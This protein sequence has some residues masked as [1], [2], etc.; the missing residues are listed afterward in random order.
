MKFKSCRR[1]PKY[2]FSGTLTPSPYTWG[3]GLCCLPMSVILLI[4]SVKDAVLWEIVLSGAF[5]LISCYLLLR[6]NWKITYD[7]EGFSYRNIFG[8][9]TKYQYSQITGID[10]ENSNLI[11]IGRKRI[12]IDS[13]ADGRTRFLTQAEYRMKQDGQPAVKRTRSRKPVPASGRMIL[14]RK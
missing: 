8:I 12:L 6:R 14:V 13:T 1:K 3:M 5:L 4:L 10:A 7:A 2:M 11:C 9:T